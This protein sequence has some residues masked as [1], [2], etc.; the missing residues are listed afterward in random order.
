MRVELFMGGSRRKTAL[1]LHVRI[2]RSMHSLEVA[3][4]S[5]VAISRDGHDQRPLRRKPLTGLV[6]LDRPLKVSIHY[7]ENGTRPWFAPTDKHY[8]EKKY[9]ASLLQLRD[10]LCNASR[11][12]GACALR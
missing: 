3:H 12:H 6:R 2:S 7:D 1:L 10:I 4:G 11:F 8:T 5:L 9:R